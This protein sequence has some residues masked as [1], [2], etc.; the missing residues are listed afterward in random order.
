MA[1]L[2]IP[3]AAVAASRDPLITAT[4]AAAVGLI[5]VFAIALTRFELLT[6]LMI[7]ARTAIDITHSSDSEQGVS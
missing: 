5:L 6:F 4:V 3:A 2:A 1:S 7:A